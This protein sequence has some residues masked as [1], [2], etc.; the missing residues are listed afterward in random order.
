MESLEERII[1]SMDVAVT[2]IDKRKENKEN[3]EKFYIIFYS[4]INATKFSIET[5]KELYESYQVNKDYLIKNLPV[6]QKFS[7]DGTPAS[8]EFLVIE[9]AT[10][11]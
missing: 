9:G 7:K 3:N 1:Y 11:E 4:P 5:L 6:Y 8:G 10:L 2:V